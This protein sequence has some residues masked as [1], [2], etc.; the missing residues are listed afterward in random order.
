M[1]FNNHRIYV[2]PFM[3]S[4]WKAGEKIPDARPMKLWRIGLVAI[5]LSLFFSRPA[6]AQFKNIILNSGANQAEIPELNPSVVIDRRN[7]NLI[8][9]ATDPDNLYISSDGGNSWQKSEI[10]SPEGVGGSNV[11]LSDRKGNLFDFHLSLNSSTGRKERIICQSSKDG[12]TTW[13]ELGNTGLAGADVRHPGIGINSRS[14]DFLLVWTQFDEYASQDPTKKSMIMLS[15]SKDGKKW[16]APLQVSQQG[17]DC[18]NGDMTTQGASAIISK[19]GYM[20]TAW[21]M[22][23]KI[24]LDRSLN[25]GTVWLTNDIE[26]EKQPGGW[27]LDIPGLKDGNGLPTLKIDKTSDRY[28]GS[29]YIV[30]A[31]QRNGD[32]DTDIWFSRS[33]NFGDNWIPAFRV[34][35]DD[36]G[37][38]QF[39]PAFDVD[40]TNGHLYI[41]YYDR[42]DYDDDRT[43]VYLAYSVDHGATFNNVRISETPFSADGMA[44]LGEHISISA[45]KGVIVPVWTRI[46]NG[47]A[48]VITTVIKDE[49]LQTQSTGQ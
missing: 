36:K 35:D 46:D 20:L 30:W 24:Y 32:G 49:E 47:I 25:K 9:V 29:L 2:M 3:T 21:A 7:S 8:V 48:T 27:S 10:T 34:N 40:Q 5:S 17:G 18:K 22:N 28:V 43:D 31:D 41:V 19:D 11:L 23:Q 45:N 14:G 12:G 6:N 15:Q 1:L 16:S 44:S 33:L 37:K 39:L 13:I 42:R 4:L 38:H 26:V